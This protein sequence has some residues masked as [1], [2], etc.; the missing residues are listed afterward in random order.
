MSRAVRC[1][2]LKQTAGRIVSTMRDANDNNSHY[3]EISSNTSY[4]ARLAMGSNFERAL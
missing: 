3:S 2:R 1:G 4:A